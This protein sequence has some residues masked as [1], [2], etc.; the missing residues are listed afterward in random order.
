M[1]TRPL[2]KAKNNQE[3]IKRIFSFDDA[4]RLTLCSIDN[5]ISASSILIL[6]DS[7]TGVI[8]T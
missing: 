1:G 8:A 4:Q 6:V 7:I 2:Y 3:V 5:P